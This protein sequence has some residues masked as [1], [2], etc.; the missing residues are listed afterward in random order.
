MESP[1]ILSGLRIPSAL[2]NHP[3]L[4]LGLRQLVST[5]FSG[6]AAGARSGVG[7][8][9]CARV[10]ANRAGSKTHFTLGARWAKW[11]LEVWL[12][13]KVLRLFFGGGKPKK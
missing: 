7:T 11:D 13:A 8:P 6:Q 1:V 3:V 2:T 10:L 9:H 4:N 12:S 5:P